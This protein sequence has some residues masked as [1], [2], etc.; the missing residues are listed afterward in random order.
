MVTTTGILVPLATPLRGN[1][2][3]RATCLKSRPVVPA[4]DGARFHLGGE[5]SV[6]RT[7]AQV[8]EIIPRHLST[9]GGSLAA[10]LGRKRW[11]EGQRDRDVFAKISMAES[12]RHRGCNLVVI[13]ANIGASA[14]PNTVDAISS[15]GR[16]VLTKR[17]DWLVTSSRRTYHHIRLPA[18]IAVG[19]TITLYFG[20][21]TK[22]YAF[23]VARI[24]LTGS[25]CEIFSKEEIHHH[26]D[27][28]IITPCYPAD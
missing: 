20:S 25:R 22:T 11:C 4:G 16:G 6:L 26:K 1:V 14:Q 15:G 17:I 23:A 5:Q 9:R 12:L 28:I 2:S 3:N 7:L 21:S 24:T 13:V 18:R 27:K 10:A 19:D 8:S